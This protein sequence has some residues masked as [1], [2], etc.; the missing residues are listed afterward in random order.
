MFSCNTV[1]GKMPNQGLFGFV[2]VG[3]FPLK[4]AK[5]KPNLPVLKTPPHPPHE[6]AKPTT[7]TK[8]PQNLTFSLLSIAYI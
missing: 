6:K 5:S 1:I 2:V 3:F 4:N 8:T 7:T